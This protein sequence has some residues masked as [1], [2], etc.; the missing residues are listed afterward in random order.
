MN[1]CLRCF[2]NSGTALGSIK[3]RRGNL[4]EILGRDNE[5]DG[6]SWFPGQVISAREAHFIVSY[7]S[8][9]DEDGELLTEKVVERRKEELYRR[10]SLSIQD[11]VPLAVQ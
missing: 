10:L 1:P 5:P 11:R 6:G 7:E 2:E 8:P 3:L 4:V 9:G